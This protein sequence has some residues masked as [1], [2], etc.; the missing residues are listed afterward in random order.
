MSIDY[1]TVMLHT[2]LFTKWEMPVC[3]QKKTMEF[4]KHHIH[5]QIKEYEC[6]PARESTIE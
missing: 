2:D 3:V 1:L 5:K 4:Q 6:L